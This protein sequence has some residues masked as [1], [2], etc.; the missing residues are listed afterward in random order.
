MS[1]PRLTLL[2]ILLHAITTPQRLQ[3][4]LQGVLLL[5]LIIL[6]DC[7]FA[8]ITARAIGIYAMLAL[9][10]GLSLGLALLFRANLLAQLNNLKNAVHHGNPSRKHI[11]RIA[12]YFIASGLLCIPGLFSDALGLLLFIPPIRQ[13][14]THMFGLYAKDT[15]EQ[16]FLQFCAELRPGDE[17]D[18]LS[19]QSQKSR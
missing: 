6:A 3:K 10:T 9:Q 11:Q 16:V 2:S 8:V 19:T 1:Q 15:L 18:A 4:H 5:G 7:Y 14:A 17:K 13:L 12:Y